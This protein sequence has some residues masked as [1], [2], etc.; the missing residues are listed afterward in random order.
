LFEEFLRELGCETIGTA[1]RLDDALHKAGT[2]ALDAAVLDVNLAGKLSYPVA[3][4]LKDRGI[5]FV[6][7]TGYGSAALPEALQ[8]TPVLKKPFRQAQLAV[9][10]RSTGNCSSP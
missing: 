1:A 3:E 9:A 7:T 10:L 5:P 6:F 2:L 8:D 4:A